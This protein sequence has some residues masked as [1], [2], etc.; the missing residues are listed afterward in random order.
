MRIPEPQKI[1]QI[2]EH[3]VILELPVSEDL[4]FFPGH[5]PQ[6]SVLP[7]V[8]MV[9]WAVEFAER[10]LPVEIQFATMEAVKFR[11]VITP[12]AV[13]NLHLQVNEK[14]QKLHFSYAGLER[15]AYSSGK[16][17]HCRL[18]DA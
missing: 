17:G 4:I 14:T 6:Q 9:D 11:Q 2:D 15:Q 8:V 16:V 13:V 3:T 1:N 10:Y 12:P 5:F 7:G 18:V